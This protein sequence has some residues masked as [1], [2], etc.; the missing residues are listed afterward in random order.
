M[1]AGAGRRHATNRAPLWCRT[2]PAFAARVAQ[3][4]EDREDWYHDQI[5][6]IAEAVRPGGVGAA[7][8]AMAP[9]NAR[10][11]RLKKRPGWKARRGW[12]A[13]GGSQRD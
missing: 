3:A 12:K 5:M 4:C 9:L 8:K 7:R 2:R 1:G 11:V 10:L 13:R 6:M